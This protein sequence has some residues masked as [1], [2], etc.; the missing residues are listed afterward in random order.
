MVFLGYAEG[1]PV[2]SN[3]YANNQICKDAY[4]NSTA[5]IATIEVL[6]TLINEGQLTLPAEAE[7][8]AFHISSGLP[9][10]T[11][12]QNSA[13]TIY[14]KS[15]NMIFILG[16]SYQYISSTGFIAATNSAAD[17]THIAC[18]APAVG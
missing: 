1:T 12:S 4:S 10:V 8:A 7:L 17:F 2:P 14:V 6:A 3:L 16:S 15:I 9:L 18:M 5:R 13:G 11:G